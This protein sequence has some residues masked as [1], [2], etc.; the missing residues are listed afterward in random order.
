MKF[1]RCYEC[2]Q[3]AHVTVRCVDR[4]GDGRLIYEDR[5]DCCNAEVSMDDL[6]EGEGE[7]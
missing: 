5:S 6:M 1:P 7:E 2:N 4:D 3:I